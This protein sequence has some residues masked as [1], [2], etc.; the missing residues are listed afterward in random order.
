MPLPNH[1]LLDA[2]SYSIT[3]LFDDPDI[4]SSS[5][6]VLDRLIERL[7]GDA[8]PVRL[9]YLFLYDSDAG[10]LKREAFAATNACSSQLVH[11]KIPT[12]PIHIPLTETRNA[13]VRA[14]VTGQMTK[15]STWNEIF[16][17]SMPTEESDAVASGCGIAS[18]ISV[19]VGPIGRPYGVLTVHIGKEVEGEM[20]DEG[21]YKTIGGLVSI[22]IRNGK[23]MKNIEESKL[24]L[25]ESNHRIQELDRLKDEFV[26]LASHELRTPMSAIRGSLSTILEG[27]TGDI[28]KDARDFLTAAYNENER[29][30]R[31]VN[32]LLNISRIEAGRFTFTV[33]PVRIPQVVNN[34]INTLSIAAKEKHIGLTY[35]GDADVPP[36]A[37]DEDK[38]QEV[39]INII[40][41]AINYTHQGA[42]TVKTYRDDEMVVTSITDTGSGIAPQDQL[43]LFKKFSQIGGKDYSRPVGGTGLGLYI[44]K[45]IIENLEGSIW[46][47]STLGSGSTFYFSLPVDGGHAV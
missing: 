40:G 33:A 12:L 14:F 2:L 21:F 15:T 22:A 25:S 16:S 34:V 10:Y 43:R 32:N 7:D 24:R 20:I 18:V 42:V 37:A 1:Q 6:H 35:E 5:H 26:T 28:S 4:S 31:L 47:D 45:I 30:L 11:S 27:Y 38:V 44:S 17:V 46:L 39:L 8:S 19:P 36:V 3:A 29:L 13:V 9:L 23:L 41:N